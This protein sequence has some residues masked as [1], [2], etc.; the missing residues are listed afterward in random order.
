MVD[1]P[2]DS[3]VFS[4][5]KVWAVFGGG[6]DGRGGTL[7]ETRI[8]DVIGVTA[9]FG[10]NS[11]PA[12]TLILAPGINAATSTSGSNPASFHKLRKEGRP[13]LREPVKVYLQIKTTDGTKNKM[14]SDDKMLI[15][16]G[17]FAGVGYRRANNSV[18]FTVHLIHWLDDLNCSS[19]ASGNWFPGAPFDLAEGAVAHSVNQV[20]GGSGADGSTGMVPNIDPSGRIINSTNVQFDL[21]GNCL[22]PIFEVI[23]DW[24]PPTYRGQTVEKNDAAKAALNKMPGIG[25][26]TY[27]PLKLDL[28]GTDQNAAAYGVTEAIL[29]A[30]TESYDYST[31]WGKL[32]GDWAAQFFFAVSP[33]V[34]FAHPIPFFGGLKWE[35]GMKTIYADEY[36]HADFMANCAQILEEVSIFVSASSQ[37]GAPAAGEPVTYMPRP[38]FEP[39]GWY[40]KN[41][42]DRRGMLMIKSLPSWL[43]N[44]GHHGDYTQGST[45]QVNSVPGDGMNPRH[46]A[47]AVLPTPEE[48]SHTTQLISDRFAEH[49]YKTELLQSRYGEMSGKL[50]FD[51]AP[52]S[53]IKIEPAKN[54]MRDLPDNDINM[55][56]TVVQVSY[57]INA[58]Q[59]QA[60]TSF[61]L[62]HIRTEAENNDPALTTCEMCG[63]VNRP[64][65]YNNAWKGGPLVVAPAPAPNFGSE[66]RGPGGG[67]RPS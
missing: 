60:G 19:M 3:Y 64:P 38:N 65:L 51:I 28:S 61:S 27:T 50:R 44:Y 42:Q 20:G 7:P 37:S 14:V 25:A 15:F 26:S 35:P 22:K 49:W 62:A 12:A 66:F 67:T 63:G 10:L 55:Y 39:N 13:K 8:D 54:V 45:G 30:S 59:A 4:A 41:K 16:D 17:Y 11:I 33:A 52:G 58:E 43:D 31:F 57:A 56:A 18:N 23:A 46:G 36:N 24:P 2:R 47:P 34:E 29:K 6:S 48:L 5:F 40:P 1:T 21:W 32:I 53:I 9:T